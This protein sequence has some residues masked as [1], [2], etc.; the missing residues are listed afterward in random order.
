M[1]SEGVKKGSRSNPQASAMRRFPREDA[2]AGGSNGN[3]GADEAG[4]GKTVGFFLAPIF[5]VLPLPPIP[6]AH[7]VGTQ[8]ERHR[9]RSHRDDRRA[10]QSQPCFPG[11]THRKYSAFN[12]ARQ[13]ARAGPSR[14]KSTPCRAQPASS[15]T[16][17]GSSSSLAQTPERDLPG[18]RPRQGQL[19]LC[20]E[21]KIHQLAGRRLLLVPRMIPPRWA[22]KSSAPPASRTGVMA[23][24][25]P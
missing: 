21:E 3:N 20:G 11:K 14:D 24:A 22:N 17:T 23:T 15:R 8:R 4:A 6:P 16:S 7:Q 1:R 2:Q 13:A 12:Q 5:P 18:T 19:G 10:G 9:Q 25:L